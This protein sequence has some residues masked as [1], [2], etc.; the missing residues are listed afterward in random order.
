MSGKWW[1]ESWNPTT[2]CSPISEG[3]A[4][5]WAKRWADR[6]GWS[7]A[8]M[9]HEDRLHLPDWQKPR[10]VAV[11]LM[12]DLFHEQIPEDFIL[13]V[14]WE[15]HF[16]KNPVHHSFFFLTKRPERMVELV[17]RMVW[18]TSGFPRNLFFGVTTE[19]AK[20]AEERLDVLTRLRKDARLWISAE[21]LL[22]DITEVVRPYLPRLSWVVAGPE[23]G[24]GARDCPPSQIGA[25]CQEANIPFWW[26]GEGGESFRAWPTIP[27]ARPLA[28]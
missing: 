23:T 2:G 12:G 11:C 15:A 5:C 9:I 7:S 4:H 17:S 13:K 6:Y 21:P 24:P 14:F 1:N 26:K 18:G 16:Y 10:W 28:P 25:A 8:P 20:R 19:N 3:C 27:G 22:E